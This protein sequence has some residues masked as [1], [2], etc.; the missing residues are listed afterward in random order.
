MKQHT[1]NRR[2]WAPSGCA[3]DALGFTLIELLVVIAII[4][5]L[6]GMLLPALAKAKQQAQR[7]ICT[8]NQKQ[9]MLA[10]IMYCNDNKDFLPY[11][12]WLWPSEKGPGWLYGPGGG[13]PSV[14][15][16]YTNQVLAYETG[17]LWPS[18]R[19]MQT[20]RCPTDATNAPASRSNWKTRPNQLSTY[21]MN[22]A[23]SGYGAM[24]GKKPNTYKIASMNPVAYS[25]WEPNQK[26]SEYNDGVGVPSESEKANTAHVIGAIISTYSGSVHLI[27]FQTWE[28][29]VKQKPGLMWCV[30]NSPTGGG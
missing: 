19:Q 8:N 2:P 18:I 15:R 5:I 29:E 22:G 7:I 23:A 12:C 20:Y 30:P 27:K 1:T 9:I 10:T 4:A 21:L 25:F 13:D 28:R 3:N 14:F 17:A 24:S 16:R 26:G 6:A 11:P